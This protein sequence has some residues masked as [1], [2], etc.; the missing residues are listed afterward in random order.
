M[1]S[2]NQTSLL[3]PLGG[4]SPPLN[5]E[6][7]SPAELRQLVSGLYGDLSFLANATPTTSAVVSSGVTFAAA[8]LAGLFD[9]YV[10]EENGKIGPLSFTTA[11]ALAA[12][13]AT[14]Y[15]KDATAVELSAAA[16]RGFG[17]PILYNL[18]KGQM[19]D[20][21]QARVANAPATKLAA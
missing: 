8:G 18:A 5:L 15:F 14:F 1:T 20:W 2:T 13:A 12:V 6:G 3:A 19:Q 11:A 7:A 16:A 17:A 4:S 9:G 21:Q 10:K